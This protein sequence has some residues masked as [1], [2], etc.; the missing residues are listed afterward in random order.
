[1]AIHIP[2]EQRNIFSI[3]AT[4][5]ADGRFVGHV[6]HQLEGQPDSDRVYDTG[7]SDTE[8]EALEEAH[9]YAAKYIA[10]HHYDDLLDADMVSRPG[11]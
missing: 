7:I 3:Y 5:Q 2:Q 8:N 6:R 10:E 1:M 11:H 4:R 9:A